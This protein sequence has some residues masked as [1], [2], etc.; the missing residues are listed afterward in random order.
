MPMEA[1][2]IDVAHQRIAN[3]Y[4]VEE[5]V[6]SGGMGSVYRVRDESTGRTVA[7]KQLSKTAFEKRPEYVGL[8]QHEYYTL[9]QLAHPLIIEVY[10]YGVD[11]RGPYYT[12][13]FLQGE[14]LQQMAPVEWRK[15]CAVLRD[16]ATSLAIL[17]SRR[18]V[19][20]DVSLHNVRCSE[21]GR[22]KLIDFGAMTPMGVTK[23]VIGTPPFIAPEVMT[24]QPI[25]GRADLYS[26]G[27]IAYYLL[28]GRYAFYSKTITGLID[29]W[30]SRPAVPS[31]I[32]PD[33][34]PALDNLVL[35]LLS[36]D[37]L[38]RPISAA[39][40][41]DRLNAIANLPEE[42]P[43]E[44]SQAYLSTP[45]LVGRDRFT[46]LFRKMMP[47]VAA[48][49]G[50]TVMVES[51]AGVGR[52]RLLDAF[53]LEGKLAGALVISA[54]AAD[55]LNGDYGVVRALIEDLLSAT[56]NDTLAEAEQNAS[57]LSLVSPEL[58]EK[59]GYPL[60]PSYKDP[61]EFRARVQTALQ[62][63]FTSYSANR[64]LMIAVDDIHKCDE[65]SVA[66]LAAISRN[67]HRLKL[68][69]AVTTEIEIGKAYSEPVRM[70]RESGTVI[71]LQPLTPTDNQRLIQSM[72]GEVPNINIV[73]DWV[74]EISRGNVRTGMELV[75]HLVDS[76]IA[77][78]QDGNWIL[79]KNL[80]EQNLPRSLEHALEA[81]ILNLSAPARSLA[82]SLS[83]V[84]EYAPL[85]LKHYVVLSELPDE[86]ITFLAIDEL[87]ASK[88]LVNA[89]DH[90]N[91]CQP[92]FFDTLQ[93]NLSEERKLGIHVK[94][95][96]VYKS[97]E[98]HRALVLIYHLQ[99]GGEGER[100]IELLVPLIENREIYN[101]PFPLQ[102]QCYETALRLIETQKGR[103][104]ERL[105]LSTCLIRLARRYDLSLLKYSDELEKQLCKYSGLIF[106]DKVDAHLDPSDRIKLCLKMAFDNWESTPAQERVLNP[107]EAVR[108]L[109]FYAG[110]L[111]NAIGPTLNTT[112]LYHAYAL[113]V[114]Y[115][116]ISAASG[117]FERL[118]ALAL[119]QMLGRSVYRKRLEI[120]KELSNPI[121]DFDE[122]TRHNALNFT[123]PYYLA[124]V[125]A[126]N[127]NPSALERADILEQDP[128]YIAHA[129]EVRLV[130][131]LY[132]GQSQQALGCL[133]QKELLA[134]QNPESDAHLLSGF[135]FEAW[136]Y[137]MS[138][139]LMGLKQVLIPISEKAEQFPGWVPFMLA[140]RGNYHF[141]RGEL[142]QARVDLEKMMELAPIG[143]HFAWHRG[144]PVLVETLIEMGE[145][146]QAHTLASRSLETAEA[147]CPYP[148]A[149]RE[150]HRV[151]AL[152][153]A[154]R[155]NFDKAS[156]RIEATLDKA[157]AEEVGGIPL[158]TLFE[159]AAWIAFEANDDDR[160]SEYTELTAK[161]Y[162]TGLN[163]ALNAKVE[164]LKEEIKKRQL[165]VSN[166]YREG[167]TNEKELGAT[168]T[169]TVMTAVEPFVGDM[170]TG[171][172]TPEERAERALV[173]LR[174]HTQAEES[175]LYALKPEGLVLIAPL[176]HN[177]PP[178][179]FSRI[180]EYLRELTISD[181]EKT[182]TMTADFD[183]AVEN[184]R[185]IIISD[186]GYTFQPVLLTAPT[187]DGSKITGI[188]A[189]KIRQ[190]TPFNPVWN[191][192]TAIGRLIA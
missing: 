26:L 24:Q 63:L 80:R 187:K 30:R 42:E 1:S 156:Q 88:I 47:G 135:I 148:E 23:K 5:I 111:S 141:L 167:W 18:I 155:G 163:P 168:Q 188:A 9:A 78:Y 21:K 96:A 180:T 36:L 52:S 179:L 117:F 134:I 103:V 40:V 83:L 113:V 118:L 59:L 129:W 99:Q 37:R 13:E 41:I 58:H 123:N 87:I 190:G 150:L 170:Q 110:L 97:R 56:P 174:E 19:H 161:Q 133:R 183:D 124:L 16:I 153:D 127:A 122:E 70:I 184:Q 116:T 157:R 94:L 95:A 76:R 75:Q 121:P 62:S 140:V 6:G 48:S 126:S 185:K 139:D 7:L 82:E 15:V 147:I 164:K 143:Q 46:T 106:W 20:R 72:F 108:Q 73:A 176:N 34:P 79:P 177:P 175:Y 81:R 100:A 162:K 53:I 67:A 32:I 74:Y 136:A 131:H 28:T 77:R 92:G 158:G 151:L 169:A 191:T 166:Q 10:D 149:M 49:R 182:V 115:R 104:K 65:P 138:G 173:I 4:Q 189:L 68:A 152:A 98:Y 14:D 109:L 29:A 119:D 71:E 3:R 86:K 132:A 84:T 51:A 35:S 60:L 186:D 69:L 102:V 31:T 61:L 137:G 112:L 107:I 105:L 154:K 54:S 50:G 55:A 43:L 120:Q 44:L 192:I 178:G 144:L 90:Y 145:F 146:K 45:P 66:V 125:E 114:P 128:R 38:A 159:T 142:A 130:A 160:F 39:E 181:A 22:A 17:H 57:V 89:D 91:F 101:E 33:I 93:R 8:F 25:D 11:E 172:Q 27:A 12:M 64:R 165:P 171:F 2:K 85:K